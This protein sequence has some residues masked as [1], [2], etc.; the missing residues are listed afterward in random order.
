MSPQRSYVCVQKPDRHGASLYFGAF[1]WE[2]RRI[3]APGKSGSHAHFAFDKREP[4]E[5][6]EWPRSFVPA[7]PP[8]AR[9]PNS[10][11][12][13][14]SSCRLDNLVEVVPCRSRQ[15]G[16]WAGSVMGLLFRYANGDR[17]CVGSFRFDWAGETCEVG[18]TGRLYIGYGGKP[19]SVRDISNEPPPVNMGLYWR[20]VPLSGKLE[21]WSLLGE[22][23]V[24][25][26]PDAADAQR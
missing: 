13:F 17:A 7:S 9:D 14:F 19:K 3:P 6:R 5:P 2:Q 15:V 26:V 8:I 11:N 12:Q 1:E 23:K 4:V 24:Y 21:W 20:E 25:H 18:R 16:A 22:G 10:M